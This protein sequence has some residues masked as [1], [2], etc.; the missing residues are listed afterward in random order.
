MEY[1]GVSAYQ[2]LKAAHHYWEE[3]K[4]RHDGDY[5]DVFS[6]LVPETTI[7]RTSFRKHLYEMYDILE[8]YDWVQSGINERLYWLTDKGKEKLKEWDAI[9]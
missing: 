2:M 5:D 1:Q 8:S 6:L 7:D 4:R 3:D 9:I